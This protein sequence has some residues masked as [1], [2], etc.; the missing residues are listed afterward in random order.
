[1]ASVTVP[2]VILA[3]KTISPF[4]AAYRIDPIC[5]PRW[6]RFV[7]AH[8]CSSVFH[9]VQWLEALYRTYGF[10]PVVYTTS[11]PNVELSNGLLFCYVS[12][13]I[14]GKR[15]VSVPFADHCEP[16][17]DGA[18]DM[19][20]LISVVAEEPRRESLRYVEVRARN[21]LGGLAEACPSTFT[22]CFHELDLRPSLETLFAKFHKSSTQRKILRAERERLTYQCG[23]SMELLNTFWD[24]LLITRRRHGLPPQPKPWFQH[25]VNVFG[26]ALQIRVA[27]H[28]L[29][30][31]A[32]IITI[33]HKNTLI[34]KY[35]CSDTH[36][37]HL[38]GTQLLFWKAMQEGKRD[39][40]QIFDLGR[41]DYENTGLITFKDRLGATRS[42]LTYSRFAGAADS[43]A[44]V[45]P[46]SGRAGR[47]TKGLVSHLP[48]HLLRLAG[49]ILYR[50][51]A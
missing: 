5:D 38:G 40:L 12:S 14:T 3:A 23:R 46:G 43:S 51:I 13:W 45:P 41:S 42:T 34:Y 33:R 1:M 18:V 20:T 37:N 31:A 36:L 10:Q 27:L 19:Q 26:E 29:R 24:L 47:I 15:L 6:A 17:T 49:I 44:F 2:E 35:G 48:D 25:L 50:H 4:G 16:L 39:D 28:G 11:P 9:S 7:A 22:Y 8:Q 21:P 32:A 30:P